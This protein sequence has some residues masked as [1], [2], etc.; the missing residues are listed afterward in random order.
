LEARIQRVDPNFYFPDKDSFLDIPEIL[1]RLKSA[2]LALR[3]IQK[4]S[5]QLRY[6][7]YYD[8]LAKY[9]S[10]T[11]PD[12]VKESNRRAKIVTNTI[13]AEKCRALFA[14]LRFYMKPHF[15]PTISKGLSSLRIPVLHQP[16]MPHLTNDGAQIYHML[17]RFEPAEISWTTISD[18]TT[19]ERHLLQ[20]NRTAFRAA[21]ASPCGNGNIYN[22]LTFLGQSTAADNILTGQP[23]PDE[24]NTAQ[25]PYHSE[26]LAA[27]RK[28]LTTDHS[29]TKIQ[30]IPSK[31]SE[32][33][34]YQGFR[35]WKEKTST[36]SSGRHLGIYKTMIQDPIL[37]QCITKFMNIAI[38][39]GVT[40]QRWCRATNV[41]IE[42]DPGQPNINRLRIIH[43]FEADY[44]LYL[45]LQ[46]GHRL[47][48]SAK[49]R[50]LIHPGQHGSVPGRNATDPVMLNQLTTDIV[51][52]KKIQYAHFDN[53]ASA[54]YDRILVPLAM[55]AARRWGMPVN[56][57]E[58]HAKTLQAMQYT[59]KTKLSAPLPNG[60]QEIPKNLCSALDKAAEHH[61]RLGSH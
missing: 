24:W 48:R 53:D 8:L 40:L 28:P 7:T 41:L 57:V 55:L 4:Q 32:E 5:K 29:P 19:I 46:W 16:T 44:N 42:K 20:Y 23:L 13:K 60:T 36:S 15:L 34:L 22:D 14:H 37:L 17:Q 50:G 54:C 9:T 43:L 6:Q 30:E 52:I 38:V 1:S 12:T 25:E 35:K 59:V 21:A 27:F 33:E 61:L 45:K 18:P 51:R 58:L 11:N 56:A 47:V 49:D 2:S 39:S 3:T 31:I 26:F 10:D